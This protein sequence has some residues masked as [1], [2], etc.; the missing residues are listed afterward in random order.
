VQKY[1][2]DAPIVLERV[3]GLSGSTKARDRLGLQEPSFST[4]Q[5]AT[6]SEYGEGENTCIT[7]AGTETETV[8]A[9]ALH[10]EMTW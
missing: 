7:L 9:A 5:P 2:R 10:G 4:H 1:G 6:R 8:A 3:E